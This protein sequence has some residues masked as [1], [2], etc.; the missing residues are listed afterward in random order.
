MASIRE[1]GPGVYEVRVF[2][3]YNERGRP[4]QTSRSV[5]GTKKDAERVASELSLKAP[6]RSGDRT[7]ADAIESW[8]EVNHHVWAPSTGRDHLSRAK[9]VANDPIGRMPLARIGVDD[10]EKW[11]ARM[12]RAGVGEA[13]VRNRH[14]ILRAALNQA[15]AWGWLTS[16]PARVARLRMRRQEPRGVMSVEEVAA[17]LEAALSIDLRAGLALRLAAIG[18]LRRGEL[19]AL[20]FEELD[21]SHLTVDS[22]IGIVNRGTNNRRMDPV[23]RDD[24][25][26]T[27][28]IRT[29]ALDDG[30][31]ALFEAARRQYPDCRYVFGDADAPPNPDRIGWWW[32]RSRLVAGIDS[33]WRLHDLRHFSATMAIAGGH[34]VRSVANRLGHA[35]AAMTLRVY[36]HALPG[37]DAGIAADFGKLLP[38]ADSP[39]LP[40]PTES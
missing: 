32:S 30:T 36:A 37:R 8:I 4:V 28:N 29:I 34:D 10:I 6:S 40:A 31:V 7:V 26:K 35:N 19:A 23:L 15:E 13:S 20:R 9:A 11:H 16:N 17:V 22:A 39:L 21:G 3:G 1:R 38:V 2:V 18:G 5:R 12:R 24:P 14:M 25:T 33:R 27:A